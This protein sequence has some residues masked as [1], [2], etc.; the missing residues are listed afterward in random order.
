M[1]VGAEYQTV[2]PLR[3]MKSYHLSALKPESST[4]CVIPFAQGPM[5]P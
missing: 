5:M 1:A 3:A 4:A 2:I